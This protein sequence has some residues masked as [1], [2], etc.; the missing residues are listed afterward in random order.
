MGRTASL[1]HGW[2]AGIIAGRVPTSS[3]FVHA[4]ECPISEKSQTI[5][6]FY[7]KSAVTRE[8]RIKK[9]NF[10]WQPLYYDHLVRDERA[11]KSVERYINNNIRNWP[12]G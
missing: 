7:R 10:A 9:I 12:K 4:I 5:K 8:A 2:D 11:Y 1:R 6:C 3:L